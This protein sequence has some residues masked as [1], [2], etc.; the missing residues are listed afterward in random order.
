M[1]ISPGLKTR[2]GFPDNCEDEWTYLFVFGMACGKEL[3]QN[4]ISE[5]VSKHGY[6]GLHKNMKLCKIKLCLCRVQTYLS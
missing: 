3:L 6:L 5:I 2:P 4:R 1:R